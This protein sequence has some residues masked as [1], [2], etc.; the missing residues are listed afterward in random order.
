MPQWPLRPQ[1]RGDNFNLFGTQMHAPAATISSA[2]TLA[3]QRS[4]RPQQR[5]G[6]FNLCDTRMY[7]PAATTFSASQPVTRLTRAHARAANASP[8]AGRQLQSLWRPDACPCGNYILGISPCN[9]LDS[10]AGP[11]GLCVSSSKATA[12]ISASLG[13]L[14]LQPLHPQHRPLRAA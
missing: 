12:S 7:A 11:S 8:A 14:H 5:G 4:L 1:Q 3:T 2:S 6:S 10:D 9:P 13:C